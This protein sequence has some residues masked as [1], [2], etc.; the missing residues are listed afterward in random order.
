M[1]V[2]QSEAIASSKG[3]GRTMAHCE[4]QHLHD[5]SAAAPVRDPVCGM[6]VDSAATSHH[7]TH[8]GRDWYFCSAGCRTKFIENPSRFLA[9]QEPVDALPGTIWTCPMHPEVRQDHS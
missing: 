3:S 1:P 6:A 2:Y 7:A 8:E 5:H 4:H 9:P